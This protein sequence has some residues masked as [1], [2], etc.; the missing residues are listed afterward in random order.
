MLRR[1]E[2][3][4]SR[5]YVVCCIHG[6]P[7]LLWAHCKRKW[8]NDDCRIPTVSGR[9]VYYGEIVINRALVQL[10][11]SHSVPGSGKEHRSHRC[12]GNRG[13]V[14]SQV[15]WLS[16]GFSKGHRLAG[17]AGWTL[18]DISLGYGGALMDISLEQ[19]FQTPIPPGNAQDK[20]LSVFVVV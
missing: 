7:A 6:G 11:P 12:S 4:G 1:V 2:E 13:R 5:I 3:K 16:V 18:M 19:E 20:Y 15:H 14:P 9:V 8:Q 17:P 10:N